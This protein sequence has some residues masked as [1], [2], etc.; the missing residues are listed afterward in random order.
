[1]PH[2][3]LLATT[4]G[5]SSTAR[6]AGGFAK[7]SFAVDAI[8]PA[9]AP[10]LASRYLARAYPYR[11][12]APLASFKSAIAASRPDIVVPCD[13][14]AVTHLLRLY[15]IARGVLKD[16][17]LAALIRR[18]LGK[19]ENFPGLISRHAFI[20]TARTLGI[21]APQTFAV[22]NEKAFDACL[23][24][25]GLPV[26]I[27]AD[28]SWGGNGV[29][30]VRTRDEAYETY[31]RFAHPPSRLRS[32]ARAVLRR[33]AHHLTAALLPSAPAISVQQFIVGHQAAS[34][35][36]AWEGHVAGAIYYDVLVAQDAIGPPSVVRRLD[37]TQMA[38]ATQLIAGHF[39]L[40][41]LHGMDFIRDANGT[42]HLIEIN[43]RATQGGTLAFGRGR[44]LP[45]ALASSVAGFETDIRPAIASD[46]VVFFPLEWQRNPA[47]PYLKSGHHDIPW[48]DPGVLD[49]SLEAHGVARSAL[50]P[51][52]AEAQNATRPP[53]TASAAGRS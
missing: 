19:P 7:A 42:V 51:L 21:N 4:I 30:V 49:A 47:N 20:A 38:A 16:A 9:D 33:D 23:A 53:R 40:S 43:P 27:K 50:A 17:S 8:C 39:G 14:R 31:R 48:D 37:C 35:F 36:A 45:A 2:K 41:G 52:V 15:D 13:D 32:L 25:L 46:T 28:G 26:V 34:A 3:V 5:W 18:S 24:A 11:A 22:A 12:L 29:A 10:V 6:L 1:M 44:D